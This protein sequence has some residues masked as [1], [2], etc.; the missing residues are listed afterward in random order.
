MFLKATKQ[1]GYEILVGHVIM[2]IARLKPSIVCGGNVVLPLLMISIGNFL[3]VGTIV[4]RYNFPMSVFIKG[5]IRT[6]PRL[7]KHRVPVFTTTTSRSLFGRS[8]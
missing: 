4:T 2:A 8:A 5:A 1:H 7:R 3:I 6:F